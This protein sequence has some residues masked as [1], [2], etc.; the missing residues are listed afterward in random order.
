MARTATRPAETLNEDVIQLQEFP[1]H[2]IVR[3][4]V[5]AVDE[6]GKPIV[7]QQMQNYELTAE[8]YDQL[9][10]PPGDWA[11]NK[12]TGTYSNDDLWHFIDQLRAQ[13][14]ASTEQ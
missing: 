7:P 10:G 11:P 14:A 12:P 13:A 9:V 6:N 8:M 3:V 2:K 4:M 5:G 1:A